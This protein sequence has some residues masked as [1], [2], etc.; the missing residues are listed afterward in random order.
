MARREDADAVAV[1][2]PTRRAQ[3][4]FR[5]LGFV[6]TDTYLKRSITTAGS[7]FR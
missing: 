1:A 6:E 4:V 5:H 7:T 2:V 3:D